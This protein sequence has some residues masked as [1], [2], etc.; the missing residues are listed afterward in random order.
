MTH[1]P[2]EQDEWMA[3]EMRA[4]KEFTRIFPVEKNVLE[5]LY[6]EELEGVEDADGK[7]RVW[8]IHF[9]DAPHHIC[10]IVIILTFHHTL[11]L[12]L[13]PSFFSLT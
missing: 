6:G 13:I 7:K 12:I 4:L 8:E 2:S 11:I 1:L 3:Y 9:T 5:K 10:L